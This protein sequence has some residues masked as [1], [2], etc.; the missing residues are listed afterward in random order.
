MEYLTQHAQWKITQKITP[1]DASISGNASGK[2]PKGKPAL[3]YI[4]L[5]HL[6]RN[7]GNITI[8]ENLIDS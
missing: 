4:F 5:F 2:T 6:Q 8:T 7:S 3:K 1:Y